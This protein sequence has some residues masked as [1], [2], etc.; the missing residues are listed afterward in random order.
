MSVSVATSRMNWAKLRSDAV[1]S[2]DI[3]G[4]PKSIELPALPHAVSEFVEKSG[5]PNVEM[6]ALAAI[7]EKDSALTVELLRYANTAAVSS[8]VTIRSVK[9]AISQMGINTTKTHLL[10][11]GMKAATRA[12]RSRLI[13]QRNFWNES[14]QRGLFAREVARRLKLDA[15]LAFLGGLLQDYLLPVLTNHFDKEYLFYLDSAYGEGRN[16][17]EWERET[18]GWDHAAAGAALAAAWNFPDELLCA[19]YYHHSLPTILER[20]EPE[21]FC[22]FPVALAGLLPDQL[23]QMRDGFHELIRVDGLCS[24]IALT[25]TCQVV[26]DEQMRLAEGYEIPNH[27][28]SMLKETRRI[29]A[30]V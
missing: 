3:K 13:N 15:G 6:N 17:V 21:F 16:L 24:Q 28:S 22:L 20:P 19:L 2:V 5:N 1:S 27:L 29:V 26:D 30:H 25:D 23:K 9:E 10:A 14:L 12:M 18:F 4:L 11:A 7:V 8:R